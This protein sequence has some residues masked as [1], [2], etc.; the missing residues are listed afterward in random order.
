[1]KKFSAD[2]VFQ[3]A[4]RIEEN[5]EL[6]YKKFAEKF[7]DN[8]K[9]KKLFLYLADQETDHKDVFSSLLKS[10][11]TYDPPESYPDEYF[12]YLRAIADNSIFPANII[13]ELDKINDIPSAL[14]FAMRRELDSVNYYNELKD[15]VPEEERDKIIQIIKEEKKHFMDLYNMK[16]IKEIM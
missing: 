6:F 14:V 9:V 8:E 3:F 11:K 1:M 16:N 13:S 10:F 2:E 4:L 15:M 12:E 5:G 7:K